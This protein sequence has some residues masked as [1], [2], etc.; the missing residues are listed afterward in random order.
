MRLFFET[1]LQA[2]AFLAA[3]PL[4]F[5][6]AA[7]FD[8]TSA[9]R[10]GR[11]VLDVLL[12]LAC[13][14]ALLCLMRFMKDEGLRLYHLLALCAGALLYVRGVGGLLRALFRRFFK[15]KRECGPNP[16]SN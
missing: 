9:V 8:L 15:C 16:K 4:G 11:A 1:S 7:G 10:R 5:F 12:L 2:E 3:V 14:G 6:L 13:A